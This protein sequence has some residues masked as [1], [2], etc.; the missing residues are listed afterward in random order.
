MLRFARRNP[1]RHPHPNPLPPMSPHSFSAAASPARPLEQ[2]RK[3]TA[4]RLRQVLAVTGLVLLG[5]A[6]VSCSGTSPAGG[7]FVST[8][9][10]ITV[11]S[12]ETKPHGKATEWNAESLPFTGDAR[13]LFRDL[14]PDYFVDLLRNA[15]DPANYE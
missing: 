13:E 15:P 11:S 1:L 5:S 8:S 7:G 10:P 4:T 3:T 14:G 9:G 2:S 6:S 12:V